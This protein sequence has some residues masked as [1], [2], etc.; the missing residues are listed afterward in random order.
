MRNKNIWKSII[1]VTVV[2]IGF[3]L[4]INL[5]GHKQNNKYPTYMSRPILINQIKD[6][7]INKLTLYHKIRNNSYTFKGKYK[8]SYGGKSFSSTYMSSNRNSV[9]SNARNHHL[10]VNEITD[11]N[12]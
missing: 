2:I 6:N 11:K 8:K 10:N 5:F 1:I 3:I 12:N 9:I 7:H 4:L